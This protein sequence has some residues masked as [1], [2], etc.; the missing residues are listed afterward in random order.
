MSIKRYDH[1]ELAS[2]VRNQDNISLRKTLVCSPRNHQRLD[3]PSKSLM[4]LD[5]GSAATAQRSSPKWPDHPHGPTNDAVCHPHSDA[6][7]QRHKCPP[8]HQELHA[9]HDACVLR[10]YSCPRAMR[11]R[12]GF[13]PRVGAHPLLQCLHLAQP[14]PW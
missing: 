11:C 12:Q 4:W 13:P 6:M 9:V 14:R 10:R 1:E 5:L 7:N 3:A 8:R 2:N